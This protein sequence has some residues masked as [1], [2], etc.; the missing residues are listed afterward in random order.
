MIHEI[1]DVLNETELARLRALATQ[2]KFVDGRATNRQSTVKRNLQVPQDDPA[3]AEPGQI[4]RDAIFRNQAIRSLAFPKS[5]TR[6]TMS[7]YDP[8][9]HYG[10]HVDE[11]LFPSTPMMI[12]SDISCTVFINE[13]DQ[14]V[15]GELE[16]ELGSRRQQVKLAAGAAVLYPS[17]TVHQVLPV[18]QGERLVAI[19]WI[20]SFV[21]DAGQRNLLVQLDELIRLQHSQADA[22]A[23]VLMQSLR[24]NLFRMWADT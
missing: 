7:R 2:I 10:P 24:T 15:G 17:T 6:P 20:Q 14:Y 13:P 23:Q 12:R 4:V 9:M 5:L 19:G 11:A 22:R 1:G 8:G 21:P 16:I 18:T 3:T